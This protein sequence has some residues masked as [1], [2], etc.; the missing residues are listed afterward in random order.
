MKG[1][2]ESFGTLSALP[3]ALIHGDIGRSNW[4]LNE[5]DNDITLID[6]DGCGLA[7][8]N[9]VRCPFVWFIVR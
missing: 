2:L 4:I 8:N 3:R 5:S 6:W 7:K 9:R 1:C